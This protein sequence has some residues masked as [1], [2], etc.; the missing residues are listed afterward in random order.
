[1]ILEE[2]T[3]ASERLS[4]AGRQRLF[5]N[6]ERLEVDAAFYAHCAK[7]DIG[8]DPNAERDIADGEIIVE[9][10]R[11]FRMALVVQR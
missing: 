11:S 5:D 2:V 3:E 10:L 9:L 8:E 7:L 6:L 4:D 1:V